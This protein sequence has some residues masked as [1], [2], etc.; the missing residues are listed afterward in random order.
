MLI[1]E[2]KIFH[3]RF[4]KKL[5]DF[6]TI[7]SIFRQDFIRANLFQ[8]LIQTLVSTLFQGLFPIMPIRIFESVFLEFI[9]FKIH[10][11]F[12]LIKLF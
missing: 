1:S 3:F 11:N 2:L 7:E 8:I 10:N 9:F 4:F 6:F 12:F 5:F